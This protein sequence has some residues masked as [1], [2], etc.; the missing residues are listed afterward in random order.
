M[1]ASRFMHNS[2]SV[3]E[4]GTYIMTELNPR[5]PG[6]LKWEEWHRNRR[7]YRNPFT[8]SWLAPLPVV[9][10]GVSLLALAWVV[11]YVLGTRNISVA[12]RC[13]LWL[14]WVFDFLMTIMSAYYFRRTRRLHRGS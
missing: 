3:H 7:G 14:V 4:L 10:P 13:F 5:V 12:D 11:P 9:F 1:L 2:H 6:G 8:V